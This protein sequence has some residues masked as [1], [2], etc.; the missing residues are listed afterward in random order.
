[1]TLKYKIIPTTTCVQDK[2]EHDDPATKL[3]RVK[4]EVEEIEKAM[5]ADLNEDQTQLNQT[6]EDCMTELGQI[7]FSSIKIYMKVLSKGSLKKLAT[8]S[9]SGAAKRLFLSL[10][11]EETK[12]KLVAMNAKVKIELYQG[13][14]CSIGAV[15]CATGG[16]LRK[17]SLNFKS[18]SYSTLQLVFKGCTCETLSQFHIASNIN[19][20]ATR[21]F[22]NF[23]SFYRGRG[24]GGLLGWLLKI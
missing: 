15:P 17:G 14:E 18:D 24:E 20:Y 1:M 2:N 22:E 8:F 21:F 7:K 11:D 4:Q 3:K 16:Y 5:V 23:S 12:E 10:L 13:C 9:R 6:L 19:F